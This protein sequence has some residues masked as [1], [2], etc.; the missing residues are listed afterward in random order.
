MKTITFIKTKSAH[1]YIAQLCKHFAHRAESNFT[2][3][4]D[5][6]TAEGYTKFSFGEAIF[7][8]KNDQL[9]VETVCA[10]Q[11]ACI[12]VQG[13][14]DSH[15]TKFSFRENLEYEWKEN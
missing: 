6:C 12:K 3:N 11:A 1:K 7:T 9:I 5:A 13:V 2:L 8:A 4:N 10:D 14:F 15:I